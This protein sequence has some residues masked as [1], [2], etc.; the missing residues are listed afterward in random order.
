M[1]G[2]EESGTVAISIA[3]SVAVLF[4]VLFTMALLCGLIFLV[5]DGGLLDLSG[6]EAAALLGQLGVRS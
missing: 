5:V 4:T 6:H 1:F 3:I 2:Q